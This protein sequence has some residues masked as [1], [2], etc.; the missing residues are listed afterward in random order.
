M[1]IADTCITVIFICVRTL[2]TIVCCSV[3][4]GQLFPSRR[5]R[6]R[7]YLATL[8]FSHVFHRSQSRRAIQ[9]SSGAHTLKVISASF[10]CV[11]ISNMYLRIC[12]ANL[13]ARVF[14]ILFF[15]CFQ[16]S[17]SALHISNVIPHFINKSK[18]TNVNKQL[19]LFF[20]YQKF[21]R[22][23]VCWQRRSQGQKGCWNI[24]SNNKKINNVMTP[25]TLTVFF[26]NKSLVSNDFEFRSMTKLSTW[27][28]LFILVRRCVFSY[29]IIQDVYNLAKFVGQLIQFDKTAP[30]VWKTIRVCDIVHVNCVTTGIPSQQLVVM[31]VN[32]V[33]KMFGVITWY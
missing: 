22:N 18:T 27:F 19:F 13:I 4:G 17:R 32:K 5:N 28:N 16:R 11:F 25:L 26:V 14:H 20:R 21:N 8:V 15:V 10:G 29:N 3:D 2:V 24:V 6:E 33:C 31:A 1:F 12:S 9:F 23:N 30:N 7:R